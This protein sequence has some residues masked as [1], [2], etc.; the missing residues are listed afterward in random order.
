MVRKVK[1]DRERA[2]DELAVYTARRGRALKARDAARAAQDA[3][4]AEY[5]R[6]DV[7]VKHLRTHPALQQQTLPDADAVSLGDHPQ[8]PS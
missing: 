2:E 8:V 3:A 4:Q 1:T 7:I 6:L 5:E